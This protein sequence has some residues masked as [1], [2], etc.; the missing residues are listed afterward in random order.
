[1]ILTRESV[2]ML[3]LLGGAL[4]LLFLLWV[5]P[6]FLG[7][8]WTRRWSVLGAA[9]GGLC[10]GGLFGHWVDRGAGALWLGVLGALSAAGG[11]ALARLG[12]W[13]WL[14]GLLVTTLGVLL[15]GGSYL[16]FTLYSFGAR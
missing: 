2:E 5:G 10:I 11:A 6:V 9:V 14:G 3:A 7:R 15:V 13:G 16:F 12:R 8:A 4:G 1:M